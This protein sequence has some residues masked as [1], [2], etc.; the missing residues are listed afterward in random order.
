[1]RK[2]NMKIIDFEEKWVRKIC[3][4]FNDEYGTTTQQPLKRNIK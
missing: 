3:R 2:H 1:M 4:E